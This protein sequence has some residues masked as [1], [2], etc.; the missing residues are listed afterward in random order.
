[1]RIHSALAMVWLAA[2]TGC[3]AGPAYVRPTIATPAAFKE[4]DGWTTAAP[5]DA[6]DRGA[7]WGLFD[8]P[9]LDGLERQVEVSNQNLA[10][11][12]AAYR[13]ARALVREQRA[14]F[15]PTVSLDGSGQ[16]SKGVA[17]T[18]DA[19]RFDIGA[20][21]EPD[22]WGAIRRAAEGAGANAAAS[23]A[24]VASARLSAQGELAA[25]Y[26]QLREADVEAGLLRGTVAGYERSLKITK[27]RYEAG[28]AAKSDLL[29][30]QT[31]LSN[32]QA[33]LANL[34][35]TRAQLEHA[36]AVLI[37]EA[38]ADFTLAAVSDHP[39]V[40]PDIPT[41]LPSTLLQR[42]PDIAA[43]ERRVAAANAQIGV[44]Q[45]AFFPA[46]TLSGSYGGGASQVARLFDAQASLWSLGAAVAETVFDGGARRA[47]VA[48]ARAGYDQAVAQYR[49]TTLAAFQDVEDQLAATRVLAQRAVLL[50]QAAQA[51]D[52]AE[53]IALNQYEAGLTDY[54][55]VVVAQASAQSARTAL[56]QAQRDRQTTAV[57]LIQSLGGGWAR[58]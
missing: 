19:Y 52:E 2:L 1:M 53:K 7:W 41:G 50:A 48:G 36:I 32:A 5:A 20:S 26:F 21:W 8:D 34:G 16:R 18:A 45:A 15:F 31:Q 43:A 42:R 22:I 23:E 56:A 44:A 55:N 58:S 24:E 14:S 33:A 51:A 29:Q 25:N 13:Q 9:V 30:A 4:A 40:V 11:A 39:V 37:G 38:P 27:N 17:A 3:A 54:T 35:Q 47:R 10:A 49:Q 12:E 28:I 57:A 6:L 46:V